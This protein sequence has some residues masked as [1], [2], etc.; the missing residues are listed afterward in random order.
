M[1]R[2]IAPVTAL[3]LS[4]AILLMGNGLQGTLLPVRAQIEAFSAYQIGILGSSYF[5]GF[6]AGCLLGPYAV[7]TTMVSIA[8]TTV[9]AHAMFVE[10]AAWWPLRAITGFCFAVLY[11]IIESWLNEKATNENRGLVFSVYTIITLTVLT[12]GQMMIVLRPASE[13]GLFALSSILVSLAA[14]PVA[15][16]KG[17]A[18]AP[19]TAVRVRVKYL[20]RISPVGAA[21]SFAVG[22][23]NGSFW[24]LAPNFAQLSGATSTGIALFMSTAVIAG[25]AAQWPLGHLSDKWDRRKVIVITCAG[26]AIAGLGLGMVATGWNARTLILSSFFGAFALPLYALC[27]AHMNDF[28]KEGG[29]VEASSGLLLLY[30]GGAVIGPIAAAAAMQ[31]SGPGGLFLFTAAAHAAM[32]AFAIFRMTRRPR[33]P[34]AE[35]GKFVDA[36]RMASAVSAVDPLAGTPG[37]PE[38]APATGDDPGGED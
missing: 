13:F 34:E 28:I 16:S 23:T 17:Q 18:P 4:V 8:S 2:A 25:A 31:V 7:R 24:S 5:I 30:A 12:I 20:Y 11:M 21:G 27:A 36:L 29:F 32:G 33:R 37:H 3:L 1:I 6:A 9:L 38:P 15:L 10:P 14:V 26:A 19:L 22:L 35:R